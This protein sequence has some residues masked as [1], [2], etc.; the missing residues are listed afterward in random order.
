MKNT[1][2]LCAGVA[3]YFPI[4]CILVISVYT[5]P[6]LSQPVEELRAVKITNV[7]SQVLFSDEAIAA[8]MDFLAATGI[9]AVLPVV[10]N[11]GWTQY[12]SD[13]MEREFGVR[14]DPRF[15]GR[16]P[17]GVLVR[18]ARRVGIEVY[19]WFE[20]GFASIYSGGTPPHGG[21]II[22][23]K[24]HWATFD[25][26]GNH[27]TKNGFDWMNG[28]HP[29]VQDYIIELAMEIINN[30]DIDGIEFSDR[31][32]AM[33]VECGY[34]DYTTALYRSEHNGADQ[35]FNF[36]TTSWRTWRAG[37][38]N[39]FY[40]RFRDSVK[41]RD[42]DLFVASSPSVYPWAFSEY[43]QDPPTWISNG[44][45]DHWIPQ[46]YRQNLAD[47]R[48]EVNR[49]VEQAGDRRDILI[50]GI[51]M[52]VGSYT[53][54]ADTLRLFMEVNR[55]AGIRGEGFFFYE[56]LRKNGDELAGFLR[57]EFYG[58][59][60]LIPGRNG[61]L[62]RP[63]AVIRRPESDGSAISGNW[64]PS[65]IPGFTG[66]VY[67]AGSQGSGSEAIS[68]Q[69]DVAENAWY[70]LYIWTTPGGEVTDTLQFTV[71]TGDAPALLVPVAD[72]GW[73]HAGAVFLETGTEQPSLAIL[74]EGTDGLPAAA[75]AIMAVV[76]RK[77][78]PD[79][80]VSINDEPVTMLQ[81]PA[82]ASID[83]N[84]PN[85]FNPSTTI[86]YTVN[87]PA[88]IRITVH[89]LL[90]RSTATITEGF[91]SPGRY[92]VSFNAAGHASGIYLVRIYSNGNIAGSH[93]IILVR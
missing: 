47:Y 69:M 45:I 10:Q 73:Q 82:S 39:D 79:I 44:T 13:V 53:V 22:A 58:K 62:R 43:L 40:A 75:D 37:K 89:D 81:F 59:P 41:T 15:A 60:A 29:E 21:H 20:Y 9:N 63:P 38:L 66:P 74:S 5:M 31:M 3:G 83:S 42:P 8:A 78:S 71:G 26:N 86:V 57:E 19:P 76:N 93:R 32:P 51:L 56:G 27:C 24:P 12:P 65:D 91:R 67:I 35:P 88:R 17:L 6:V 34:D 14:I 80:A 54:P 72:G 52:N 30:Y 18:E 87:E 61:F 84:Y 49:A 7:D 11:A 16:D 4:L 90:G 46:F 33:P 50:A 25:R 85:P 55:A 64:I 28:I 77:L 36:R 48:I 92:T 1:P 70:D 68:Y 2:Q 23:E